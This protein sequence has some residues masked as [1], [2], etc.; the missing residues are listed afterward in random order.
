MAEKQVQNRPGT[1]K[2]GVSG[3]PNGRP[4]GT[5]SFPVLLKETLPVEEFAVIVAQQARM[6]VPWACQMVFE[7]YFPKTLILEGDVGIRSVDGPY[8]T[9]FMEAKQIQ[10]AAPEDAEIH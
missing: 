2:K 6:R 9:P 10:E 1:F 3:N 8:L 7:R 5:K 4:K